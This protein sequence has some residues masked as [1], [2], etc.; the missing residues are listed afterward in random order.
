MRVELTRF[1]V[2]P[3]ARDAVE[4]WMAFLH[5]NHDT[6]LETLE[7]ERMYVET[8]FHE[9]IDGI[10]Y[11]Y[12]YSVQGEGEVQRVED[13]A[14]WIDEKHVEFWRR[15]IDPAYPP[16]DLTPRITMIPRRVEA[17]MRPLAPGA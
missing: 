8:I 10:D 4:E 11:L 9:E 6:V 3:G 17:A 2:L 5:D 13:S 1:R 16:V 12:W 14:H 7:P 15:C